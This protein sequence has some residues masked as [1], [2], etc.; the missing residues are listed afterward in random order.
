MH[1]QRLHISGLRN[2]AD[3]DIELGPGF[4]YLFGDNGAGKTAVLEA[5]H[6]LARGRSFRASS[7]DRLV[8]HQSGQM[9]VRVELVNRLGQRRLGFARSGG[10]NEFSLDGVRG[11]GFA[12]LAE[13]VAVQTILPDSAELVFGPPVERRRFLD[14]G[15]FHVEQQFLQT[16]RRYNRALQQRNAWLKAQ[17]PDRVQFDEDPWL[18]TILET[19]QSINESRAAYLG[20]LRK[21]FE[22][23]LQALS[24][25][26]HVTLGY[27]WGGLTNAEES[28]K[29]MSESFARDVKFGN[30][31]RG[32]HRA[33][34]GIMTTD[35]RSEV[36]KAQEIMSR[37]QAKI[38]ASAMMLSQVELLR[39]ETGEG[40]VVLIDD[41]GAELD[42]GHWRRFVQMLEKLGCQVI[43]TSTQS[44]G[45]QA[46][47]EHVKCEVFHVE[48]GA[49]QPT[50]GAANAE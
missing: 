14:W 37:G 39:Q 22:D 25:D 7:L 21:P 28:R 41:F 17:E 36:R 43:T 10:Q 29:K 1:L 30:T 15:L 45:S 8:N 32:P 38:T 13:Q 16:S 49:V 34:L 35:E 4:N 3:T 26:I 47:L 48:Q 42:A 31:H 19:G 12:G 24:T 11:V 6:V 18:E 33:E 5:V 23:A 27:D 20:N 46:W 9:V 50:P 2:I 44:P 40:S